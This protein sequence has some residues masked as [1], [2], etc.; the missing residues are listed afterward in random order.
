MGIAD[1][2]ALF[3]TGNYMEEYIIQAYCNPKHLFQMSTM[4]FSAARAKIEKSWL[5]NLNGKKVLIVSIFADT[6]EKQVKNLDEISLGINPV[7]K[8][9]NKYWVKPSAEE[10]PDGADVLENVCYW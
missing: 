9:Y 6:M 3:G 8:F 10:K 2:I 5:E 4:E 7:S 1:G